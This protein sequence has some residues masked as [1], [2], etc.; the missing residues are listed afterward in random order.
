MKSVKQNTI[1][2]STDLHGITLIKS[3]QR[4]TTYQRRP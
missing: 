1:G 2:Q 4:F 3:K